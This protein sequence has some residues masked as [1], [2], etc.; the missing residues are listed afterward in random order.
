MA[1]RWCACA[2]TTHDC[3]PGAR[4]DC[5]RLCGAQRDRK[6][7]WTNSGEGRRGAHE[8]NFTGLTHEGNRETGTQGYFTGES[9]D[10]LEGFC[11][12]RML[13]S[14]FRG[15]GTPLLRPAGRNICCKQEP[16]SPF[17][18]MP[19]H[20]PARPISVAILQGFLCEHRPTA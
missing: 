9:L 2:S 11:V 5:L 19:T 8:G 18:T 20:P 7:D 16:H 4:A 17:E 15:K 6:A 3:M 13:K 1:Y 10:A 14:M 12:Q